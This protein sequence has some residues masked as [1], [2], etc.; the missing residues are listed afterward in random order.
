MIIERIDKIDNSNQLNYGSKANN[1]IKMFAKG[2]RIPKSWV[3]SHEYIKKAIEEFISNFPSQQSKEDQVIESFFDEFPMDIYNEIY[4]E[5]RD[6]VNS[7]EKGTC[8]AIRSSHI[9]EDGKDYSFSGLFSTELNVSKTINIVEAIINCWRKSFCDGI[10]EYSGVSRKPKQFMPCAILIQEF[11]LSDVAGVVFKTEED[12]VINSTWGMAKSIVDGSTGFDSW[13]LNSCRDTISYTNNKDEITVPVFALANPSNR[14]KFFSHIVNEDL[15]VNEFNNTQNYLR[16]ALSDSLKEKPSLTNQQIN[17]IL[18]AC[19]K[20]AQILNLSNCDVEWAFKNGELYILQCRDVTRTLPV[21]KAYGEY[22]PLVGGKAYGKCYFVETE[23][24][25]KSFPEGAIL[26]AKRLSGSVIL[27]A[28]KASG[29][30]VE[31][32]SPLSHSAIIARELGIPAIGAADPTKIEE[33]AEYEIDGQ[34]GT[35]NILD[36]YPQNEK[37]SPV[38]RIDYD[39]NNKSVK[40]LIDFINE[41][42]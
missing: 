3:I 31:S 5:V 25:A 6:L 30:I 23:N 40:Q 27:A 36:D 34:T 37:S 2:V 8:F 26:F 1:V 33:G 7:C 17:D 35:L 20:L 32:K 13:E 19:D 39:I 38:A 12:Y 18:E 14:S 9:L 15:S 41:N 22:L 42:G 16:V 4:L 11:V 21:T 24:D 10:M 29:C 28:T